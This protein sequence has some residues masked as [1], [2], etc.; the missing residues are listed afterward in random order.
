MWD[1]LEL[2]VLDSNFPGNCQTRFVFLLYT[3][4][5]TSRVVHILEH[6]I[7]IP[8]ALFASFRRRGLRVKGPFISL[9]KTLRLRDVKRLWGREWEHH[10]YHRYW[11]F[12]TKKDNVKNIRKM[13]QP[14]G[15]ANDENSLVKKRRSSN[16]KRERRKLTS[17]QHGIAI[18]IDL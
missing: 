8:I 1:V 6:P 13:H 9:A 16:H 17:E 12:L 18:S 10:L 5:P 2:H 7:S 14:I 11:N 4:E 3:Q 15:N